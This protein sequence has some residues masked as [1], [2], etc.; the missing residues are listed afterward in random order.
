VIADAKTSK[1][2]TSI[3]AACS[4]SAALC[5]SVVGM[6]EDLAFAAM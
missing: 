5:A 2:E 6:R 4:K 1:L 3:D